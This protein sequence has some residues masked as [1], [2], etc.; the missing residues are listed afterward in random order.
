MKTTIGIKIRCIFAK[1]ILGM[2]KRIPFWALLVTTLLFTSCTFRSK[3]KTERMAT[4]V[5]EV[6]D[7]YRADEDIS[8]DDQVFEAYDYFVKTKD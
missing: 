1:K 4:V 8:Q 3:A 2:V 6:R 7:K 5:K